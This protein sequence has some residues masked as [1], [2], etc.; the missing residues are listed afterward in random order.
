MHSC[1][2]YAGVLSAVIS[3]PGLA[4]SP[5]RAT[6]N[7]EL[8]PTI[9]VAPN[10]LISARFPRLSHYETWTASDPVH[11]GRLLVCSI[12][13]H[14]ETAAR[15]VHCYASLDNGKTWPGVLELDAS[16]APHIGQPA[17]EYG[18]GDT[19]FVVTTVA[20]FR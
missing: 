13:Q 9:S 8:P 14:E 5:T 3:A 12:V 2:V 19:A 6:R 20:P 10:T 15:S 11:A 18:R 1:T 7:N 17:G 4:Q 16:V